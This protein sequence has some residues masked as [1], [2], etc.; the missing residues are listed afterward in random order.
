MTSQTVALTLQSDL[1]VS[2]QIDLVKLQNT[3]SIS[4]CYGTHGC[5]NLRLYKVKFENGEE[6]VLK[7]L[8][9]VISLFN[10][11]INV[12][13]DRMSAASIYETATA[14][15]SQYPLENVE[16]LILCL[17]MAKMGQFG[18][19]YNRVDTM[20]IL[21]FWGQYM[22]LK[23]DNFQ[24]SRAVEFNQ[25]GYNTEEKV[26]AARKLKNKPSED[27]EHRAEIAA[28]NMKIIEL[29]KVIR[30]EG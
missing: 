3:L 30:G 24:V 14:I 17:K 22:Q 10:A 25:Y 8:C 9:A 13:T 6:L 4:E 26:L 19:I 1:P 29:K 12:T 28:K 21:D 27:S 16:D 23:D 18:K 15:Y 20:V 11:A 7:M 5:I 2:L